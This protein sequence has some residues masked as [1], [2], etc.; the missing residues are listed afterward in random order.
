MHCLFP[1]V[2]RMISW[3]QNIPSKMDLP[4][5]PLLFRKQRT[6]VEY[7]RW[8]LLH[9]GSLSPFVRQRR[10]LSSRLPQTR[11]Y[12]LPPGSSRSRG[13]LP[14]PTESQ[15]RTIALSTCGPWIQFLSESPASIRRL[16]H[17]S[18]SAVRML[19]SCLET[20]LP[21]RLPGP[22][23]RLCPHR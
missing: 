13:V 12:S 9:S 5:L 15:E 14:S 19:R 21:A 16:F 20:F 3:V 7:L 18:R 23:P 11:H 22:A 1:C 10:S 4:A 17:W 6:L 2:L 8:V